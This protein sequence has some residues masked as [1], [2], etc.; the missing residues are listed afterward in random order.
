MK[1]WYGQKF[2]IFPVLLLVIGVIWLLNDL[3]VFT[4]QIP[5]LP[6]ALIVLSLLWI[7][8]WYSWKEF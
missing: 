2:P 1:K 3:H 7:V 6:V 5:W 4:I 8:N